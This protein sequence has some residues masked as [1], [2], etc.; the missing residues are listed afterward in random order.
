MRIRPEV[1]AL[2]M[3]LF[4]VAC[5]AAFAGEPARYAPSPPKAN[6]LAEDV[7]AA[8]LLADAG[9][10]DFCIVH[11]R[12]ASPSERHAAKELQYFLEQITGAQLPLVTDEQPVA[13]H[14]I[15]LGDN[16]HLRAIG[17]EIDFDDLGMEG[18]QI[19]TMPP[20]LVIAGG[21]QR[22]TMYGV[23]AFLEEHLGCR[24][25]SSTVSHI[26]SLPQLAIKA[27]D[28]RQVPALEY[29][30]TFFYDAL[31][32][33]WSARNRINGAMGKLDDQRG[34]K[35]GY[36]P[37]V[38]S[39][40]TLIPPD[41]FFETHP[42]WFSLVDGERTLVGRFKRTQLCLTNEEMIQQA[43]KTV[44]QWIADH[45]ESNI[46]SIS[47]NDGPGGWCECE[48]CRALEESQGGVHSAPIIYFVNR[49]AESIADEHPEIAID[50]LAYSY[51][52]PAP[53]D[54][55]PLP[56]VIIRLTTGACASHPIADEQCDKNGDLRKAIEDWF[57][58]TDRMYIWDYTVNFHQYL[59]P[60]P[61][62]H[63]LAPNIRFFANH[64]ICGVFEQGSGDAVHSDMA[65][66]KAYV[67]A[68]L[69]WNPEY[70]ENQAV[71]EFLDGYFGPAGEPI[72]RYLAA[73]ED[74][75][76]DH[77][78]MWMH[79]SP[80][81]RNTLPIY[82]SPEV[83]AV[84]SSAFDEAEQATADDPELLNRVKVARLSLDYVQLEFAARVSALGAYGPHAE[85]LDDW[86]REAMKSFFTTAKGAGIDYMRETGRPS[87]SMEEY[88]AILESSRST[89]A[90]QDKLRND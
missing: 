23:Y 13:E 35:T 19:R 89:S 68:K 32:A 53:R 82:L 38:H 77:A 37:F 25:Y 27:I 36:Y 42:E 30:E 9:V 1:L 55:K 7:H 52:R 33:D 5:Y 72:G 17:V 50:T 3:G 49:I 21:R 4:L 86:Y 90:A 75:L 65:P 24:W 74:A 31:D 56:N 79:M 39:F 87:S 73:L 40:F 15:I 26:P 81:E 44:K 64:G 2:S 71:A 76:D 58:L 12:T 22:G 84:A 69:L 18:F 46:I 29:R 62:L 66:L 45:P 6:S 67:M 63:T 88:R 48:H 8:L 20:H 83:L 59:L 28:D 47:Q 16:D 51:S 60:F 80:F 10:S 70:D 54:L 78:Y 11:S 34:G 43:I 41:E 85:A 57:R 61:N 14:E